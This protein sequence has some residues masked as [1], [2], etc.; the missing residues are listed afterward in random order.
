MWDDIVVHLTLAEGRLDAI[1]P[2]KL[3]WLVE[4]LFFDL[5]LHVAGDAH[6][7]EDD[8]DE[9][10][11][12]VDKKELSIVGQVVLSQL[13]FNNI[14]EKFK[15]QLRRKPIVEHLQII[16]K[17]LLTHPR[18]LLPPLLA[19]LLRLL[20][21]ELLELLCVDIKMSEIHDYFLHLILDA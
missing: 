8:D 6:F 15:T 7:V 1:D 18:I 19:H 5:S 9:L 14:L 10:D 4:N 3:L 21:E 16:L 12:L 11:V 17:A 13:V 2:V 20:E